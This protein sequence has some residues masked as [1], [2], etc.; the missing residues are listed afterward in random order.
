MKHA[1]TDRTTLVLLAICF[2]LLTL[3]GCTAAEVASAGATIAALGAAAQGLLDVAAPL[4]SPEDFATFR[5][6]VTTL[7][8]GVQATK[9]VL[10][11]IVDAFEGFRD[12]VNAK[13]ATVATTLQE[14]ATA[15]IQH[16]AEIEGKPSTG[17]VVLYGTG[18]GSAGGTAVSRILSMLKHGVPA[19]APKVA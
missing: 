10:G 9:S 1:L 3:A 17:E 7:D 5:E 2:A 14:Q 18:G 12:G 11:A 6:G 16:A 19:K 15:L 4:M 13:N 8:G